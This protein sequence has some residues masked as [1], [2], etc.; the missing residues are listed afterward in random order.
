MVKNGSVNIVHSNHTQRLFAERR[1]R[2]KYYYKSRLFSLRRQL[3][4][5]WQTLVSQ[6]NRLCGTDENQSVK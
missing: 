5:K 6:D 2:N 3:I 1:N 4:I